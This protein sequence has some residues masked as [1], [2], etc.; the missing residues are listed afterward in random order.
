MIVLFVGLTLSITAGVVYVLNEALRPRSSAA[1]AVAAENLC[2][3]RHEPA[4]RAWREC[5]T[6]EPRPPSEGAVPFLL[7]GAG[8]ALL[9]LALVVLS[10]RGRRGTLI[11][12]TLLGF[13]VL[14]GTA[15]AMRTRDRDIE[16]LER[17]RS[18]S[19]QSSPE[20]TQPTLSR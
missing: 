11:P 13:V 18:A 4:S 17:A 20:P 10:A 12:A 15:Y 5:L 16:L 6:N 1:Q 2:T 9:G 7:G 14:A 19:V 3:A 8:A